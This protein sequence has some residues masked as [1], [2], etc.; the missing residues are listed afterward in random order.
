M[1]T[2]RVVHL[3]DVYIPR[4]LLHVRIALTWLWRADTLPLTSDSNTYDCVQHALSR[5]P[6]PSDSFPIA[7]GGHAPY[8]LPGTRDPGE[9]KLYVFFLCNSVLTRGPVSST[10][11]WAPGVEHACS[12]LSK[13]AHALPPAFYPLPPSS[14]LYFMSSPLPPRFS[15]PTVPLHRAP[16]PSLPTLSSLSCL[17]PSHPC[18]P[19][20]SSAFPSSTSTRTTPA[21]LLWLCSSPLPPPPPA[22]TYFVL[23]PSLPSHSLPPSFLLSLRTNSPPTNAPAPR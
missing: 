3:R 19:P 21:P 10:Q 17:A 14:T 5:T 18:P 16:S 15:P 1:S 9:T 4:R 6:R 13:Y 7:H 22:P 11:A 8:P 23:L 2:T 12:T 20:S